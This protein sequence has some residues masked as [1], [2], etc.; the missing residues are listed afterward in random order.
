[1]GSGDRQRAPSP[2]SRTSTGAVG[3]GLAAWQLELALELL[4]RDLSRNFPVA[5]LA[6]L[7]GLSRSYFGRAFKLSTGLPPHRWLLHYRIECAQDLLEH[8]DGDIAAISLR[9]GFSDQSHLTRMFHEI[10]G[11]SPA[12][13]RRRHKASALRQQRG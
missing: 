1:M 4:L 9:C 7:C 3:R 5:R 6:S 10:V 8:S 2:D 13:W 12:A 11:S